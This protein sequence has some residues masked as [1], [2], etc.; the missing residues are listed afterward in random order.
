MSL[1]HSRSDN[2]ETLNDLK[3]TK[4]DFYLLV[5]KLKKGRDVRIRPL[6]PTLGSRVQLVRKDAHC[7]RDGDADAFDIE[8]RYPLFSQ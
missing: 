7:N 6:C 3:W 4:Q 1:S 5:K 8:E 2:F